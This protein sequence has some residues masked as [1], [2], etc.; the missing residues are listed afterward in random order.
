[1]NKLIVTAALLVLI[2][3][4]LRAENA[5]KAGPFMVEPPTLI[6]LGFEWDIAGDE[7][8]NATVDVSYRPSGQSA[9][10]EGMPLLRMGGEKIFRAPYTVPNKFAGSI[11]DLEPDTEYE[12][13][14]TMKDPDGVSGQAVQTTKVRTRAEPKEATGGRVLHVYPPA[15]RGT[16]QE[17]NFT[18]LMA[19]YAGAGTGDWNVVFQ[20]KAEPGDII[21]VHAGLYKGDR[22]NYVDPLSTTFDGA[23]LLTAKGTP[24][25]PIVI[26]AAGDGEVIF[27]GDG[28]F[29]LFDVMGAEYTIFDGLTIRNTEVAFWAGVKD[30]AGAKGLTV[31]NCRIENVGI[32]INA[33]YAGSKDFYIADNIF[34]GRDDR[35]R[36]LGWANPGLYGAHPIN[37]YYAIKVYGSGHVIAHNAVAFFHDGIDVC[38]HGVP[39]PERDRWAVAID[40]YDNDIHVSG[41]DFI[42]ADGGVHNIRVMRNRGVNAAHTGLSAQPIFG[43]PAYYIRNVVYNTPVALKFSNPAGVIVYHNT[44]IAENRTAQQV[45]NAHFA[46]NLFLGTDAPVGIAA[47]GGPTAYSTY[48]YDGYRPNRAA[49]F[50]YSW[51]GP[52][53][54]MTVDYERPQNQTPRYKTLAEVAAATGQET[55][56]IE[57]DYDIFESLRPPVPPD[58][59]KPGTPYEAMNLNFQL[60]PGSKAVDAGVR[61]PNV[62]DGFS[63]KAPDLGAYEVG[64]S[65]PVYGPRGLK[66]QPFYR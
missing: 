2:A 30:V 23:Y 33:Q 62:N 24:D 44:I 26:R 21:L 31:R 39:E 47:L 17:P 53:S 5:T 46:N 25:R 49:E 45:S 58:S 6:C 7:N 11:L 43:G 16:K 37:S 10:K 28:A 51:L 40:I 56:G 29:R 38:T 22:H 54:G 63:G 65:I 20:H 50:Q 15:W 35:H 55:H 4:G 1:M 13:R 9:W 19:A 8:R 59:S 36:I 66:E 18:G 42:E 57:V 60:K 61:L 41:D 52:R 34:L 48:D 32:G 12:V 14:L 3:P 64:Q 27:D